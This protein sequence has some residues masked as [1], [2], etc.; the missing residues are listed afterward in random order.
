MP[1]IYDVAK[2]A[3]VSIATVSAVINHTAYVSPELTKR[4]KAA[5]EELDYT[6]NQVASSLQT[7]KSRTV[8]MLIPDVASPDPFYGQVVRG[9]EDVLRKKG[10]LLI[11]GH[12]YNQV[13]EQARYLSAFR[14]RLVDGVLLFQAPGEDEELRRMVAGKRP[15]VFVGRI[16]TDLEGDVVATDI[17][18]GTRAGVEHLAAKGHKRIALLTVDKS[19]SVREARITGWRRALKAHGLTADEELIATAALSVEGGRE[20]ALQ[21][22]GLKER[23]T[24][25]FVD[26]LVFTTG[27]LKAL[28]ELKLRCPD[29]VEVM[30]SDDAEWLDVF[31]PPISTI[32]QPSYAVGEMAAEMLLKRIKHPNRPM[33]KVL[34][35]PEL[36]V[37]V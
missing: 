37:R 7:R 36:R 31:Q 21:L 10:Y 28:Q 35:K 12:T 20:I 14:S 23:P 1:T 11:L 26:N 27:V 29:D 16:P 4:V 8:A 13:E 15:L 18:A 19:M 30:S 32:V 3:G 33:Q 34:L 17:G 5:V 6:V 2:K 22:L 9:A 24:A 25:L